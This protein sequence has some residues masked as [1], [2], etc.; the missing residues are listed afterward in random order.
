MVAAYIKRLEPVLVRSL[1]WWV[2][3]VLATVLTVLSCQDS[4]RPRWSEW[5][6]PTV[7][8][9]VGPLPGHQKYMERACDI[10]TRLIHD[11]FLKTPTLKE[12][13]RWWTGTWV[14]SVPFYRP[15]TSYVFWAQWR[16][17]GDDHESRYNVVAGL[18]HIAAVLCL[19][20]L[21]YRLFVHFSV[22]RPDLGALMVCVL[23]TQD[24]IFL[25][26]QT[27]ITGEVC[28]L[29]KNQPDA[30][31]LAFFSLCLLAYLR[32]KQED[33]ANAAPLPTTL[34]RKI[35][36]TVF[37]IMV[38]LTKEAAI[39]LP[40]LLLLLEADVLRSGPGVLRRAFFRLVPL[41]ITLAVYLVIRTLALRQIVGYQYGSN[42]AWTFRLATH[43]LGR[44]STTVFTGQWAEVSLTLAIF[45]FGTILARTI[46]R[47]L[48]ALTGTG[49]IVFALA[50]AGSWLVHQEDGSGWNPA[51]G[52]IFVFG[53]TTAVNALA[54]AIVILWTIAAFRYR[55]HFAI[56]T[57]AWVALSLTIT[58]FSPSVLHRYYLVHAGFAILWM[59]GALLLAEG[60]WRRISDRWIAGRGE[61]KASVP[62]ES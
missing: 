36:P 41:W 57:Y 35:A 8:T 13:L 3:L 44:V 33:N 59:G 4:L 10:D 23:F 11:E 25:L 42:D 56:V 18:L 50:C 55:P 40:A 21:A 54:D 51:I 61:G 31:T 5:N 45:A 29:W 6:T 16:L 60:G 9:W 17:W 43:F 34:W 47:P 37:Y 14:G 58:L 19:V 62:V 48:L 12:T 20:R 22:P 1:S 7:P 39:F 27:S 28:S 24:S 32:Q 26:W 15:L 46:H 38:C 2:V 52:L 53:G 49:G 30:L